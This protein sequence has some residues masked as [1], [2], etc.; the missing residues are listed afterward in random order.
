[1][2]VDT[3]EAASRKIAEIQ[4]TVNTEH[5]QRFS[6]MRGG[7]FVL[8]PLVWVGIGLSVFQQFVGINVIYYYS[9]ALWQSVGFGESDSF[10]ITVITAVANI[11]ATSIAISLIDKVGRRALLLSGAATMTVSLGLMATAFAQSSTVNGT[12]TLPHGWGIVA[13]IAANVFAFGFGASWAP[14]VWVLLGEMFPNRIRALAVGLAGAAQWIANFVVS[15]TFP[16]LAT[17][18]LQYA[19]GFY[20]VCA[21]LAFIFVWKAVPETNGKQLES[22]DELADETSLPTHPHTAHAS[23]AAPEH[24]ALGETT[25]AATPRSII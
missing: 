10:M 6:D 17:W 21:L 18:G 19:Y 24:L 20:G 15:T 8:L 14:V 12:L 9:T 16:T 5:R 4:Q 25:T 3:D 2:H 7:R 1:M 23:S 22:M 11:V 13:L